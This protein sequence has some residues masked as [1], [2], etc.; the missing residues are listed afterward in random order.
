MGLG[1][2]SDWRVCHQRKYMA[3]KGC[4]R[5]RRLY[6]LS[7]RQVVVDCLSICLEPQER[8][9]RRIL[10][11][12]YPHLQFFR[13]CRLNPDNLRTKTTGA[14]ESDDH[15]DGESRFIHGRIPNEWI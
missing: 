7:D 1:C 2:M 9:D 13:S 12:G 5:N 15:G 4:L 10:E 6:Y 14:A 11:S 8:E 3:R